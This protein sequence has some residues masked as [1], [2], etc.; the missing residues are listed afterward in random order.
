MKFVLSQ[1]LCKEGLDL[2]KDVENIHIANDGN[3]EHYANE[4][5]DADAFIVR[6]AKCPKEIIQN[7]PNLKVIG[8]TGVGYDSVDVEEATKNGIPV[9]ITPGANN[10]S[11]AEHSVAMMFAVSKNIVQGQ[12][13]TYK[14]NFEIRNAGK[15]FELLNKEVGFIGLG[16]IGRETLN[17]CKGVGMKVSGYDP[18]LSKED[19]E[20]MGATYYDDFREMIK[21]CDII[22]I[23][24]PLVENTKN[25]ISKKEL[26][27]MKNS[28]IIINCSR[29]GIVNEK[30]LIDA[31]NNDVIAGAGTD[32]FE[33]EPPTADNPLLNAKNLVYSPHSAAQ[34]K[35]AVINMATMCAKGCLAIINGEKW[36]Y[37]AN[38]EVYN[39]TKWIDKN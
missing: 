6:I 21:I 20:S 14:G 36:P 17:I 25:M 1:P 26:L 12:V 16:A 28:A 29:G 39:H 34:T 13:E 11:V 19:I 9:V 38:K 5:K 7:S 30:D 22:S 33:Q 24:V 10:R 15:A 31:L 23:H 4:L 27:S 2:L 18:F 8:R 37:V 32:V 35:E 3:P